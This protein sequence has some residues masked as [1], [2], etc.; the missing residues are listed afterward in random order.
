MINL[1]LT[2]DIILEATARTNGLCTLLIVRRGNHRP[3]EINDPGAL[4]TREVA[5]VVDSSGQRNAQRYKI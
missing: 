3:K 5:A 2:C 4:A 1:I